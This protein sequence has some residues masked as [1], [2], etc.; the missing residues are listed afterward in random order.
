MGPGDT[1]LWI[2]GMRGVWE[3][4]R[5]SAAPLSLLPLQHPSF[6]WGEIIQVRERG[7]GQKVVLRKMLLW[8]E[9]ILS[10]HIYTCT[11]C[12]VALSSFTSLFT[13]YLTPLLYM[14]DLWALC[15]D[16]SNPL[17]GQCLLFDCRKNGLSM[18]PRKLSEAVG[19]CLPQG[20]PSGEGWPMPGRCRGGHS[21]ENSL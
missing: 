3:V 11:G 13:I 14:V 8:V 19:N 20:S 15:P 5:L 2:E 16:S 4:R 17:Q 21:Q 7:K 1:R 10:Y 18:T 6:C 9:G 12:F